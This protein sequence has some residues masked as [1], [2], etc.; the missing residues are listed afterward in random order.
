MPQAQCTPSTYLSLQIVSP[1]R[2]T[3]TSGS[4]EFNNGEGN[5]LGIPDGTLDATG[6]IDLSALSL[7]TATG[8][9]QFLVTLVGAPADT[10]NVVVQLTWVSS[11]DPACVAPGTTVTKETATITTSLSGDGKSGAS[12]V[13]P[14]GAAVTDNATVAGVNASGATG[15]VTYTWYSNNTCTAVA[16]AGAAQAITTP[17]SLPSSAPVTLAPG[18][19]YTVASYSGDVGNLASTGACG[20]EVLKVQSPV[21]ANSVKQGALAGLIA[22]A[23][24]DVCKKSKGK[25]K[26]D[27]DCGK[28]FT[29]PIKKVTKSLTA[30]WWLDDNHLTLNGCGVFENE[31]SAVGQL[32]KLLKSK[33]LTAAQKAAIQ[34]VIDQLVR[35]DQ[36]LAQ[37]AVD[38][39]TAAG[40][41]AA[42]LAHANQEVAKA[43]ALLAAGKPDDAI[44]QYRKAW[45]YAQQS[46]GRK[47]CGGDSRSDDRSDDHSD[48]HS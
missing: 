8:L 7:N 33:N 9:P 11:F 40:G 29:S 43:A 46:L 26:D 44:D 21:N 5:P 12:I 41:N 27:D 6:S 4:I 19:Y 38:E 30:A 37:T 2:A 31:E 10:G 15:T 23:A 42:K 45:K 3:Y 22:L 17:G 1:A 13:V 32:L 34:A 16:S 36:I 39:A 35:A 48:S 20:A 47:V 24:G 18:T 14:P 28:R 25:G